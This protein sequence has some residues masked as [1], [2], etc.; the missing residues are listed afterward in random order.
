MRKVLGII[1]LSLG[2]VLVAA[3]ALVSWVIAPKLTVLPSDTNTLRVY[4]G[5]AA[6][7]VNPTSLSGTTYGPG[8]LRDV[9]VTLWHHTKI[10]RTD[11]NDAV[12]DDE[13]SVHISG[14]TVADFTYQFAVDRKSMGA[15]NA[16]PSVPPHVGLTFNWPIGTQ[17]HDY[18]G[19]VAD[20]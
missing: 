11:G 5:N 7:L 20:T 19:W 3:A 1:S 8:V 15:S 12:V 10:V 13:R 9:P 17:K 4:G 6:M 14:F 16:F 2:L 18:T